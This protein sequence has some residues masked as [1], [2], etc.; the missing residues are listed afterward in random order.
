[1]HRSDVREWVFLSTFSIN[2][3]QFWE[4]KYKYSFS[5]HR[6]RNEIFR[7]VIAIFFFQIFLMLAFPPFLFVLCQIHTQTNTDQWTLSSWNGNQIF[8][9]CVVNLA[10]SEMASNENKK[11]ASNVNNTN[12]QTTR[13]LRKIHNENNEANFFSNYRIRFILI[14]SFIH[15]PHNWIVTYAHSVVSCLRLTCVR[16]EANLTSTIGLKSVKCHN[17][18]DSLFI[19]A[20]SSSVNSKQVR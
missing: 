12:K 2:M 9:N 18:F 8:E 20:T 3:V 6:S 11:N 7:I 17:A 13:T 16:A 19:V 15:S 10:A 14:H 4:S 1:M 5:S